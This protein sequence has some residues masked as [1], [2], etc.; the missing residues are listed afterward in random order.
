MAAYIK[1]FT[2]KFGRAPDCAGCTFSRDW[3]RLTSNKEQTNFTKMAE[4][5]FRLRKP[6][7]IYSYDILDEKAG[8]N[9]RKRT[10]GHNMTEEFAVA[11]LTN[12]TPEQITER[13]AEFATLPEQSA[14]LSKMKVQELKDLAEEKGLPSEEWENLK[15]DE[16]IS[17]LR[18]K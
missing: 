4:K 10:Y 1:I 2:E 15:K 5:T 6:H 7:L 8:R 12:G 3:Q 11:Y 18:E 14:D 16:L 13:K 9:V 17:Y